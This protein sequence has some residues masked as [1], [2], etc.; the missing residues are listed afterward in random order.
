MQRP[1]QASRMRPFRISL[2]RRRHRLRHAHLNRYHQVCARAAPRLAYVMKRAY[3]N[4]NEMFA[5]VINN[6]EMF[7]Y[8][9]NCV[10]INKN[11]IP[12][13]LIHNATWNVLK[14]ISILKTV[15]CRRCQICQN[16][17]PFIASTHRLAID[18]PNP[19]L[20]PSTPSKNTT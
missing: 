12:N 2:G 17:S 19:E 3:I 9:I 8:V 5:Y 20:P 14:C 1:W 16:M 7:A 4:E 11:K 10:Y 6:N 15:T 13:L 18:R